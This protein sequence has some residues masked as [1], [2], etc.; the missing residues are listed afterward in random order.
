MPYPACEYPIKKSENDKKEYRHISL[1]NGIRVLLISN[2]HDVKSDYSSAVKENC[3]IE[4]LSSSSEENSSESQE[5]VG[6]VEQISTEKVTIS[7]HDKTLKEKL[8]KTPGIAGFA[9]HINSG[10]A[11]E[12]KEIHGLAHLLEH[13][14]KILFINI[15]SIK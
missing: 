9:L 6:E 12:D 1:E 7:H 4:Q 14:K 5:S 2:K 8:M 15:N 10:C 11:N 3:E 13:V